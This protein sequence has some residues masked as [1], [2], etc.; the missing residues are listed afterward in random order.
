MSVYNKK[1]LHAQCFLY[2]IYLQSSDKTVSF[3]SFQSSKQTYFVDHFHSFWS[4]TKLNPTFLFF[5]P[6]T[7]VL[8]VRIEL[9]LRLNIR[10]RHVV[11][12]NCSLSCYFAN[13]CH[14]NEY[15]YKTGCKESI[16]FC[17][18]QRNQDK[19]ILIRPNPLSKADFSAIFLTNRFL[20]LIKTLGQKVL[21]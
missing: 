6:E 14:G 18:E 1:A 13:A 15:F 5:K 20:R 4:N 10:V 19:K 3:C 16:L 21:F 17:F 12:C 7:F 11:S 2:F 9:S 8:K